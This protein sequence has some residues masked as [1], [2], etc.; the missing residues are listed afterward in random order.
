MK[1]PGSRPL[2]AFALLASAALHAEERGSFPGIEKLMTPQEFQA[3]ELHKLTPAE[4]EALDRFLVRYT[5]EDSQ[6]LFNNDEEV[7]KAV[8][9]QVITSI[10]L[11][12]FSGWSGD[13][14]FR[15]QNGQ[16]WQ[17]RQGGN[18]PYR[19]SNPEVRISKNFMGFYR[20]ELTENGKAV[21][22]KRLK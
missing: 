6:V 11:P 3:T 7:K 15:L 1:L 19:G 2:Y 20:M 10:I 12:P 13:T 16:V 4:R 18:Y 14:V 9:E 17:Q 21:A 5:A 22:V 8:D